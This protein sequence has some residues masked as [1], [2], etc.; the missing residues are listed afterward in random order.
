ML[1]FQA[2]AS[3]SLQAHFPAL[4]MPE[5]DLEPPCGFVSA[6][7]IPFSSGDLTVTMAILRTLTEEETG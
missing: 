3:Q 7:P 5:P 1:A 6:P 2:P 4:Q